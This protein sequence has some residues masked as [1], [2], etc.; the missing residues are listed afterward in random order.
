MPVSVV[1]ARLQMSVR[2]ADWVLALRELA[3]LTISLLR[4]HGLKRYKNRVSKY[5]SLT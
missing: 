2:E 1:R 3:V 5:Q 4:N